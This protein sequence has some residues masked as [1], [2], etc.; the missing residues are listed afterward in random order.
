MSPVMATISAA[1]RVHF[2]D[3]LLEERP[4]D[5]ARHVQVG[6]VG[7]PQSIVRARQ[8]RDRQFFFL[9]ANVEHLIAGQAAQPGGHAGGR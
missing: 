3:D 6:Q 4:R 9:D 8:T 2:V 7:D 5:A 1:A